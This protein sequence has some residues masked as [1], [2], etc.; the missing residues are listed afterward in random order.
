MYFVECMSKEWCS[1]VYPFYKV[2]VIH[3]NGHC[4]HQFSCHRNHCSVK[5][6]RFLDTKDSRSTGNLHKHIKFCWGVGVMNATDD[7]KDTN[8]V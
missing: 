2:E 1:P 5:I 8:D 3:R 7:A 6:R 4:T